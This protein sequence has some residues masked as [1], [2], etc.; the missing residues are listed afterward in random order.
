MTD[1]TLVRSILARDRTAL[2]Y[3]YRTY[4]PRL[5]RF[6]RIR[7]G[8]QEDADEI[9]Q[10]TLYA[11]LEAVRD[12]TGKSKINTFLFSICSHKIVDY[13]RRKKIKQ[14]VF[15]SVPQLEH[16]VS[17]LMSP[18]DELEAKALKERIY[19]AL[20]KIFPK[21][22]KL[23]LSKYADGESMAAIARKWAMTAKGVESA[24]FRAR[25]AFVEAFISI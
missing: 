2:L 20:S 18:E 9:L 1:E 15:S 24:L 14:A 25:R 17:P 10:D 13:Y 19:H 3:F 22:Q 21:Y 7:V 23:L 16:I 11:F 4:K 6:I 5:D 12:Y 8:L